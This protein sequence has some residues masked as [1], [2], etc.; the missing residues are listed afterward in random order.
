MEFVL[1]IKTTVSDLKK[2][3]YDIRM[4]KHNLYVNIFLVRLNNCTIM[5]ICALHGQ[6]S[7]FVTENFDSKNVLL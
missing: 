3:V 6:I 5:Y 4:S 1:W 2:S 7:E